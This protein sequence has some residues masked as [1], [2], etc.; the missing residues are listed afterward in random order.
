MPRDREHSDDSR[1]SDVYVS[2]GTILPLAWYIFEHFA[3]NPVIRDGCSYL[4]S[5]DCGF[6][7]GGDGDTARNTGCRTDAVEQASSELAGASRSSLGDAGLS[8]PPVQAGNQE[9][10]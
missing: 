1:L 7:S 2:V 3:K 6:I 9:R 10:G 5:D 4:V 8:R